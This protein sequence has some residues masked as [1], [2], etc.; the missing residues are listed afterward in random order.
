MPVYSFL[1]LPI[2][3]IVIIGAV[4]LYRR[5]MIKTLIASLSLIVLSV[6][7]LAV[8]NGVF[9]GGSDYISPTPTQSPTSEPELVTNNTADN[10]FNTLNSGKYR[11]KSELIANGQTTNIEIFVNDGKVAANYE[12]SG[13]KARDIAPNDGYVYTILDANKRYT[14]LPTSDNDVSNFSRLTAEMTFSNSGSGEFQGQILDYVEYKD[15]KNTS[16]TL[17]IDNNKLSGIRYINVNNNEIQEF[18]NIEL[19]QN[20]PAGVFDLPVGYTLVQ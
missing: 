1:A 17:F 18:I 20:I 4:V 3:A 7:S 16:L 11:L 10:Y 5:K 12:V 13:I 2:I 9:S 14:R 19:D 6:V 8:F 15:N